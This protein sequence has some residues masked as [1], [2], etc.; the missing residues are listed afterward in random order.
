VTSYVITRNIKEQFTNF[1]ASGTLV[2]GL[3]TWPTRSVVPR[4][5]S[6]TRKIN[7]DRA[8]SAFLLIL[9]VA[10]NL[11]FFLLA[12]RFDYPDILRSPAGHLEPLPGGRGAP[13]LNGSTR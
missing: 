13:P 5:G 9:T 11:F 7:I 4:D 12:R 1:G 2:F 3:M 10:F 8:A 6:R